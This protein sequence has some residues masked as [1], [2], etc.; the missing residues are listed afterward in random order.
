MPHKHDKPWSAN[1]WVADGKD[2]KAQM[3]TSR[4][5]DD[6]VGSESINPGGDQERRR[7]E[8]QQKSSVLEL[9]VVGNEDGD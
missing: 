2:T 6:A 8:S 1:D 9:G 3:D 4:A 7:D 5:I